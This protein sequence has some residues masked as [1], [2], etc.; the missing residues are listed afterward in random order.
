P[1]LSGLPKGNVSQAKFNC[2]RIFVWLFQQ[3]VTKHVNPH[4][5]LAQRKFARE[6]ATS[7]AVAGLTQPLPPIYASIQ[8]LIPE[9][10]SAYTRTH[11]LRRGCSASRRADMKYPG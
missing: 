6:A 5:S 10:L 4:F 7:R 11:S 8:I 1:K 2:Q 3:L 9:R